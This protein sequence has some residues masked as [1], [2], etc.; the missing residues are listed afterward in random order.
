MI[1]W[2]SLPNSLS[3][4][5]FLAAPLAAWLI[6]SEAWLGALMIWGG[7]VCS[8]WLDGMLARRLRQTTLAGQLIDHGA[9]AIFVVHCLVALVSLGFI[10]LLLP[11]VVMLAF[12]SYAF[13]VLRWPTQKAASKLGKVNG[14]AYYVLV[15][16]G[17]A[18]ALLGWPA[19]PSL[20]IASLILV[21][22]TVWLVVQS[23][24]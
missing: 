5:R 16:V 23:W 22:T 11:I 18:Y 17:I 20:F 4:L 9:D 10:T 6:T 21:G 24:W 7:A 13:R 1:A 3:A 14:V 19:Y 12:I 15:G 8:D 2:L